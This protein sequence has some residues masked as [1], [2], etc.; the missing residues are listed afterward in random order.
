V[1]EQTVRDEHP[2]LPVLDAATGPRPDPQFEP[3]RARDLHLGPQTQK[4]VVGFL[5]QFL[6]TP[7][8]Q[9]LTHPQLVLVTPPAPQP[10]PTRQLVEPA[11]RSRPRNAIA[12]GSR[13]DPSVRPVAAG[14]EPLKKSQTWA[15][16]PDRD[17]S[18]AAGA[19]IARAAFR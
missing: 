16:I 12:S 8:V 11:P 19:P 5:P 15:P 10:N 1:S 14:T 18:S 4:M 9:R 7:P 2:T 13:P 6:D 3:R 17:T